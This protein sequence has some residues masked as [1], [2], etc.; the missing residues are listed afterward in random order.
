[1]MTGAAGAS[2][3]S[4]GTRASA[5]GALAAPGFAFTEGRIVAQR[6]ARHVRE[7]DLAGRSRPAVSVGSSEH[8]ALPRL[9]NGLRDVGV[10]LGWFG[11][12]SR[13]LQALSAAGALGARVPGYERALD[14]LA[15]RFAKGSSGGPDTAARARTR[16]SIIAVASDRAGAPLAAVRLEGVNPYDFT[17]EMLAWGAMRALDGGLQGTGALGPVDGF[18]LDELEAAMAGAGMTRV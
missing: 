18:G 16:S 6:G 7:F 4:G 12:L 1:Y 14:A 15:A 17:A 8:F 5:A 10:W 2:A 9:H 11:P 3:M 13:P